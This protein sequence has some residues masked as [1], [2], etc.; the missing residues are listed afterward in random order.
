MY[1]YE[2]GINIG[3]QLSNIADVSVVTVTLP[4]DSVACRYGTCLQSP[5]RHF[6]MVC[7]LDLLQIR[8]IM[9]T[10][11]WVRLVTKEVS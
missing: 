1:E 10:N 7:L 11:W 5:A 4:G 9:Q 6:Y 8:S 2:E 3:C